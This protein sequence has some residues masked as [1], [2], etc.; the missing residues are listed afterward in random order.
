[1]ILESESLDE[2]AS[3]ILD[4]IVSGGQ[5]GVDRAGLDVAIE[6]GMQH[7]GW[8]PRGRRAED[9][10]ISECYDLRETESSDY[11]VRTE[12][13]VLDSDGTLVLYLSELRGGT[14]LT[15]RMTQKHGRPSML[16]DLGAPVSVD[17]VRQW[18]AGEGIRV[19]NV[20]GPR[21]SQSE[22]IYELARAYLESVLL[23]G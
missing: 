18:I 22:G 19:L 1:V 16:V 10:R 9:G 4:R 12:Q 3:P 21:A 13:N 2:S 23:L 8:C 7:G 5:T 11:A 17:V 14:E 6:L 15:Y 20:A